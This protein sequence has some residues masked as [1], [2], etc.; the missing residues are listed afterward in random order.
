MADVLG[1]LEPIWATKTETA[2][3]LRGRIEAVLNWATVSGFRTGENPARW[4]GNLEAVL[5]KPS[6]VSKVKHHTALPVVDMPKFMDELA[7]RSATSARALEFLILTAARSGEVR[8]ATW[9]EIDLDEALWV[10]PASRMKADR[11][12]RVP[13]SAN[14]V[15]LLATLPTRTGSV[16][17]A[18]KGGQ[19]SDMALSQLVKRMGA[20]AVPHG[21]RSTF[22]DWAADHTDYP[23][24]VAEAA[25]AHQIENR[26]EAAYRR[27]DLL[28][29]RRE[30]MEDWAKWCDDK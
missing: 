2:S 3:R 28:E 11:E 7:E 13:L 22:R 24:E 4:K 18:P 15:R 29:K 14:A 9:E 20:E 23:R 1:S 17:V 5:P 8:G 27:S 10:V 19:L 6:K 21:F 16:F 25:L 30:M 26:V 12:H